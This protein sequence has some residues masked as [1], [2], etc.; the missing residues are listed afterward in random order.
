MNQNKKCWTIRKGKLKAK[1][2]KKWTRKKLKEEFQSLEKQFGDLE[3]QK[4]NYLKNGD[5]G[6]FRRLQEKQ[7]HLQKKLKALYKKFGCME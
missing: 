5:L 7:N 3:E 6:E 4:L 2:W 1:Q